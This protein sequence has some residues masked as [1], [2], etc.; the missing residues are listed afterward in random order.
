MD[1]GTARV[2][3]ISNGAGV[4]SADVGTLPVPAI[5]GACVIAGN[6]TT[7]IP[8]PLPCAL[9]DFNIGI[10]TSTATDTDT[11]AS[12]TTGLDP[13]FKLGTLINADTDADRELII[14]EF[15]ALLDNSVASN[16]DGGNN[17]LNTFQLNVNGAAYGAVSAAHTIRVSE[18][19]ITNLTKTVN[20]TSA[21]AGN[22]VTYTVTFSNANNANSTTAFDIILTDII[23]AKMTLDLASI[24]PTYLPAACSSLTS[25]TSAGNNINLTFAPIPAACRVTVTY[26]ATLLNSVIPGEALVNDRKHHIYQSAG[27]KWDIQE[28]PPVRIHREFRAPMMASALAAVHLLKMITSTHPPHR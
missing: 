20:P 12:F 21:D 1:D 25:N 23:P 9:A 3:F 24:S 19:S 16:N 14:V 8:D 10:N 22:T 7:A 28:I 4:S 17:R 2:A 11:Q 15:N 13:Q 6:E 26:Q 5:P 27:Y 18:P